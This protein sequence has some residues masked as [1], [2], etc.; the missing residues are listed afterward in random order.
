M[1]QCRIVTLVVLLSLSGCQGQTAGQQCIGGQLN[2]EQ[3]ALSAIDYRRLEDPPFRNPDREEAVSQY[4]TGLCP[5]IRLQKIKYHNGHNVI[6]RIPG[7]SQKRIVVGAHYDRIGAGRC[8][9]DNSTGIV[10]ISR[11]ITELIALD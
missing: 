10:Q 2:L 3:S 1:K 9:T 5:Q 11:L 4:F 6:C 7:S 8:I